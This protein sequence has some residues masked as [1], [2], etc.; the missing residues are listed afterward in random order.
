VGIIHFHKLRLN[1]LFYLSSSAFVTYCYCIIKSTY[2]PRRI[3]QWF[4][5]HI[6]IVH[7]LCC[8]AATCG[9]TVSLIN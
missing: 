1:V 2:L 3:F 9:K 5:E 7:I 6:I 8:W 4:N